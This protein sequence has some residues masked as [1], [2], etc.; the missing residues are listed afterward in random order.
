MTDLSGALILLLLFLAVISFAEILIRKQQLTAETARKSIHLAGGLGCLLFPLLISSWIAVMCLAGLFAVIFFFGENHKQ[1]KSLSSVERRSCGSLLFPVAILILFVLSEGRIWLYVSALLVLVLADTAA[2]L[3]GTRF[4]R[5]FYQTAPGEKKSLEGTVMFCLVGFFA[6]YLPLLAFSDFPHLICIGTALLMAILLGGLEAVSIGGTDN[7][8]VPL[9]TS[10]LL[11]KLP[12]KPPVEIFF[13]F[14]SFVGISFFVFTANRRHKTLQVRPLVIFILVTYAAWS[15][16]SADWMIPV[17]SGFIIYNRTCTHCAPLS[18]NLS[19]RELL[20]PLYPALIMLFAANATLRLNVWFGPFLVAMATSTS[21]CI[22]NRYRREI[23]PRRMR[24]A[25]LAA[26][27]ILPSAVPLLFCLPIQGWSILP[28][29]P[30]LI[31]L[32][33]VT[34]GLYNRLSKTPVTHF[35]WNYSIPLCS[36]AASLSYA[37]FQHMG[38]APVMAPSTWMEIFR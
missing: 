3:A 25:E 31:P 8:F 23:T 5:I 37:A 16:G 21:L 17:I 13:Q 29:F 18:P 36:G 20:R 6:V 11:L 14:V 4:G 33:A 24:G 10:F 30:V 12:E 28:T 34:T 1:L 26:T 22:M 38:L 32:C 27:A 2:A 35:A 15:L 19:A 9:A 7:L